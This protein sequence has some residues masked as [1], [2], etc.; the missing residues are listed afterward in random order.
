MKKWILGPVLCCLF[1]HLSA[2]ANAGLECS[3]AKVRFAAQ[4]SA[5][6]E[7]PAELNLYNVK[8]V[9][10]DLKM[11]N[12][13]NSIAGSAEMLA[14]GQ[15]FVNECKLELHPNL[16]VD[17]VTFNGQTS[18][19]S[20]SGNFISITPTTTVLAGDLFRVKVYYRGTPPNSGFFNGL[21]N[22]VS[23]TWGNQITW[24]LSEPNNAMHWWPCKQVLT[25]KIDSTEVRITTDTGLKAGSN[26]VLVRVD[27]L[28]KKQLRYVWKYT[29]SIAYYLISVAVGRYKEYN[30]NVSLPGLSKPVLVQNFIY[31]NP[32]T[33]STFK[34]EIDKTGNMLKVFSRF[35]G[36]YP[37]AHMK[38]GHC[39]APM[40]GGMEHNTMT[41]Q[42]TFNT[43]LTSHELAHQ[44]WGDNVT[45]KSWQD[46][47]VNEGFARYSEYVYVQTESANQ[48][49]QRLDGWNSHVLSVPDGS[50]Y[51][52][53]TT[54]P[55]AIFN[56][57]LTYD[58]GALVLHML[59]WE[60]AD[61]SLYFRI[62]REYQSRYKN[63]NA[64]AVEFRSVTEQLS[65]RNFS[66][67]FNQW[68]Y[69]QGFPTFHVQWN[70]DSGHAVFRI[71]QVPSAK[72]VTPVFVTPVQLKV[73]TTAGDTLVRLQV[74]ADSNDFTVKLNGSITGV[75][76]IDP[77]QWILDDTGT[78]QKNTGL[79][80]KING[81][82]MPEK[83]VYSVYPVPAENSISLYGL[84]HPQQIRIFNLQGKQLAEIWAEPQ[85]AVDIGFL[86]DGVYFLQIG[87]AR[88]KMVKLTK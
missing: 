31:D 34:P 47:W 61:D 5:A 9:L 12:L 45:C 53:D 63:S 79:R 51:V 24:S 1:G 29:G 55:N 82:E 8:H 62:F 10:L 80:A 84:K 56:G 68:Y 25:D 46:I 7:G 81:M 22:G 3:D 21:S 50:V 39:M 41:T 58:K 74:T 23:P 59:R 64:S 35:Y 33:L 43:A 42:G 11:S 83:E 16:T 54:N 19:V 49:R 40:N 86:A 65:G 72:A 52:T 4:V 85:R 66:V 77:N 60:L 67:F 75:S 15:G 26:G 27:T 17:S 44:W 76:A 88:V 78:I 28:N 2:Q 71:R 70:S 87:K 14:E 37:F 18:T 6:V 38:Y 69:G 48:A 36:T 32:A 30:F 73:Q 57:R 20:R 13:N